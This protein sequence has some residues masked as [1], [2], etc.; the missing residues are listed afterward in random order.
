[1]F[2]IQR[3]PGVVTLIRAQWIQLPPGVSNALSAAVH[4]QLAVAEVVQNEQDV[5]LLHCSATTQLARSY[6]PIDF[7]ARDEITFADFAAPSFH[8]GSVS[9][10]QSAAQL[11]ALVAF[12]IL[13]ASSIVNVFGFWMIGNSLNVSANFWATI[14]AP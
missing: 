3:L 11:P 14:I 8:D 4:A 9:S 7:D 2:A 13:T 1:M 6:S 12:I 10:I 5:G